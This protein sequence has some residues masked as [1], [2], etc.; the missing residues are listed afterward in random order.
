M[1]KY[2]I[3]LTKAEIATAILNYINHKITISGRKELEDPILTFRNED[4][5]L[6]YIEVDI[7]VD[8]HASPREQS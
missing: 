4:G 2:N 1:S 7:L 8:E 3:T 5:L 6:G